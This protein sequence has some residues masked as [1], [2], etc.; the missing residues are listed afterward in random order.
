MIVIDKY[1]EYLLKGLMYYINSI[2]FVR[3]F[4]RIFMKFVK[5]VLMRR[6]YEFGS[7]SLFAVY[8]CDVGVLIVDASRCYDHAWRYE[9]EEKVVRQFKCL[10][11][12]LGHGV[13]VDVGAYVGFY[14]VLAARH[15]WRVIAFEPN[16]ISL[17]LLRYNTALHNVGDRVVIVGKAIGDVHGCAR[18]SIASSPSESSFTKYL[19]G[20]LKLLD[21]VVEVVTMDSVLESLGIEDVDSLVVKVDVEGFGLRVLRGARK[22]IER[23]RPF[24]LF[25]VHRTFD[26]EDE[27]YALKMLKDLG[28]DFV[29]VESRSRR[30]FIVY[31]YPMEKG[32]ICREQA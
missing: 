23:F 18:F 22:T 5:R 4:K 6:P 30:N 26:E 10:L 20:E 14:T 16:P 13:F 19:R 24:I 11:K 2:L 3:P 7:Q 12:V 25:E 31:A 9:G 1:K 27:I 32:C 15:G 8:N 17:I 28:Y 29:V 21:I